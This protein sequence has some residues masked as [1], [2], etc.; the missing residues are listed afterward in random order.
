MLDW[1]TMKNWLS[2]HQKKHKTCSDQQSKSFHK[3]LLLSNAFS[4]SL[5][6][7]DQVAFQD[8]VAARFEWKNVPN[9]SDHSQMWYEVNNSCQ[10]DCESNN[11][12]EHAER[13]EEEAK[14]F[15]EQLR[16]ILDEE[17]YSSAIS[18]LNNGT[19][20]AIHNKSVFEDDIIPIYFQIKRWKS[21]Q[22]QLNVYGFEKLSGKRRVYYHPYFIKDEPSLMVLMKREKVWPRYKTIAISDTN[23]SGR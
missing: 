15:P 1:R 5:Y 2:A 19:S 20:F 9:H 7:C 6:D 22:K 14:R 11:M 8:E 12:E 10:D 13:S 4:N 21:F 23:A 17:R 16:M 3:T 18:W